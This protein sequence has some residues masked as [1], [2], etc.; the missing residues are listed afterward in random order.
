MISVIV[1]VYNVQD[2]LEECLESLLAQTYTDME[3]LLVNDGS[4]DSSPAIC[5]AYAAEDNRIRVIHQ[6][7]QG[8]SGARNTG[9][10]AS[11]GEYLFFLDSD[12]YL[13]L[14]ALGILYAIAQETGADYVAGTS[15]R[16]SENGEIKLVHLHDRVQGLEVYTGR[17]KMYNYIHTPKMTASAC[18][19]LYAREL[20]REIS[21]PVGKL[22]EDV[23]TTYR[24]VHAAKCLALTEN[25]TYV[26]RKREGSIMLSKCSSR[27]FSLIEGK[28]S[29]K[30]FVLRHYPELEHDTHVRIFTSILALV[31]R[32]GLG[33]R[34]LHR[35]MQDLARKYLKNYM[36]C[37]AR[38]EKKAFAI[39]IAVNINLASKAAWILRRLDKN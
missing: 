27:D 32:G 37:R 14:D 3:I 10:G 30:E 33:D 29:E 19:K 16:K 39:L 17:D 20:F 25:P 24:L 12:D 5:E 1:P 6:E 31:A 4:T 2:Y 15:L 28:L 26:Y 22:Y 23:A 18:G 38:K 21:F 9:I 11:K 34:E 8:L 13:P 36:K 35:K 7:N